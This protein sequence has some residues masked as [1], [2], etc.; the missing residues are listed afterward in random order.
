MDERPKFTVVA[1]D[2]RGEADDDPELMAELLAGK[3]LF[4]PE[5]PNSKV[6]TLYSRIRQR[7]GKILR[8]RNRA[9]DGVVGFVVWLEELKD[10]TD[11]EEG[12][13]GNA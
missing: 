5:Y 4:L 3:T 13:D 2:F 7:H 10:A 9:I 6:S 11:F 8:R 1:D 12:G